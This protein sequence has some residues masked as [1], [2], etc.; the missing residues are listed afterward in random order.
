MNFALHSGDGQGRHRNLV[1]VAALLLTLLWLG[2]C[3]QIP[4]APEPEPQVLQTKALPEPEPVAPPAKPLPEPEPPPREIVLAAPIAEIVYPGMPIAPGPSVPG[5]D[6][7]PGPIGVIPP[8]AGPR[9][10][11]TPEP[12][13]GGQARWIP[14]SQRPAWL[15]ECLS[16][17][18]IDEQVK[19]QRT[20]LPEYPQKL[21]VN[22]VEGRVIV[23]FQVSKTGHLG[24]YLVQPGTHPALVKPSVAAMR[25]WKFSVP[26]WQ[27]K[28]VTACFIQAFRYQLEE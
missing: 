9:A 16:P 28:P 12:Q 4:T 25:H 21:A 19:I 11:V 6:S 26:T 17:S 23:L 22:D 18:Q 10:R 7:G 20:V 13:G 24:H 3:K 2:G 1:P 5:S 14:S 27:G 8:T 15:K